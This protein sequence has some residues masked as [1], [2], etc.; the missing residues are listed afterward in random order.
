MN[1]I[2]IC[3]EGF[4]NSNHHLQEK[5]EPFLQAVLKKLE[6]HNWVVSILFCDNKTMSLLN[7][8]Y[9]NRDEPTDV[10]SFIMGETDG[11]RY[12]AGD[13]VISPEMAAENARYFGI[14]PEEELRR[15]LIHGIL[16]LAGNDHEC[17]NEE[18][19]M[20]VLQEKLLAEIQAEA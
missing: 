13:I 8:Q 14:S 3:L 4:E 16:H 2:E 10:L 5:T 7:K 20:L 12:I 15:L 6:K 9:R 19:P 17:N 1:K 18:E 11:D